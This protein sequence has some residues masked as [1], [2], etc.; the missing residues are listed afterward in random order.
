MYLQQSNYKIFKILKCELPS[1]SSLIKLRREEI[2]YLIIN[3]SFFSILSL[4]FSLVL[5]IIKDFND[6]Y[7]KDIKNNWSLSPIDSIDSSS[8]EKYIL[9]K[10]N[11][12]SDSTFGITNSSKFY[13]F[14]GYYFNIK[15]KDS[16]YNYPNFFSNKKQN[17]K[18]CGIDNEGNGIYF[19]SNEKCPINFIEITSNPTCSLNLNCKH[20]IMNGKYIH[21]SNENINGKIIVDFKIST[22]SNSPCGDANYDNDIC[23]KITE[24]CNNIKHK[25]CKDKSN[26]YG[27]EK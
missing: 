6:G 7:S 14:N 5:L 27:Y 15:R 22:R 13:I 20:L 24:K 16:K 4:I 10:F 8:E 19:P 3:F 1:L 18:K 12:M 23:S 25:K 17:S 2:K 11:G 21:Y 26:F 9:G